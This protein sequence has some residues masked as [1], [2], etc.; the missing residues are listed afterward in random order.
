MGMPFIDLRAQFLELEQD[1]RAAMDKVL[2]HGEFIMGPE[3]AELEERLAAFCG[4]GHCVSCSS[5]TSA[6]LLP[7][8]A[9]EL[10]PGD[11]VLTTPFAFVATAEVISLLGATP[12]FV[13][14]DPRSFNMDASALDQTLAAL[15]GT[16]SGA[17]LPG[18]ARGLHPRGIISVDLFGQ[19]A[20]YE[21]INEVASRHGLFVVE[22]AA[23]SFGAVCNGKQVGNHGLCASTSF[24]PSRPLGCYGDGGAVLTHDGDLAEALRSLREH[25]HDP[26][27]RVSSRIGIDARLDTI[28]AAVLLAK[29]PRF[30]G[31]LEARQ[32]AAEIYGELLGAV[33]YVTAP[34]LA[35]GRTSSWARY[36]VLSEL[37]QGIME[38]LE[39]RGIPTAVHY[40]RPLHLHEAFAS[41]GYREGQFPI[42]ERTSEIIFSL[43]MHAYMDRSD[44]EKVVTAVG[45]AVA[46]LT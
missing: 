11:A 35:P 4:V 16:A 39:R 34:D 38:F 37:R 36:A 3:V 23:Q 31:E 24:F 9:L 26:R 41:L 15:G 33:K 27:G 6:L 2:A 10:G 25:G 14:I 20:D 1:I 17:P 32:K 45:D 7:L 28:Q 13:D 22:D 43:P 18:N 29:L 44:Q 42:A 46:K 8:L 19:P 5:G 40:P 21:A 12:V 30:A